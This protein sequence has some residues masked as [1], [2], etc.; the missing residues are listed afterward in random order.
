MLFVTNTDYSPKILNSA[1]MG[2]FGFDILGNIC[3]ILMEVLTAV[4]GKN[5]FSEM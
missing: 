2:L 1:I 3:L 4:N 5:E